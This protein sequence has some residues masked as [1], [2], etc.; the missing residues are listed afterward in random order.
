M[1]RKWDE[2]S[3]AEQFR[4][5]WDDAADELLRVCELALQKRSEKRQLP[6]KAATAL[7][8]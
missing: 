7:S 2:H 4:R 8:R 6:A 3:I 5:G 1:D